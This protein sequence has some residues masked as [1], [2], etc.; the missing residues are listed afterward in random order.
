[1]NV[2]SFQS[3]VKRIFGNW[4]A[5]VVKTEE[6]GKPNRALGVSSLTEVD[7][8]RWVAGLQARVRLL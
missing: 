7:S 8:T 3:K 4:L 6:S 1:M 5:M 2:K